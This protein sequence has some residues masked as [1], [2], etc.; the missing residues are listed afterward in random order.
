MLIYADRWIDMV[1]LVGAFRDY[2][3]APKNA[4]FHRTFIA[5]QQT[6]YTLAWFIISKGTPLLSFGN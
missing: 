1:K 5:I 6:T 2:A 4:T 3:N